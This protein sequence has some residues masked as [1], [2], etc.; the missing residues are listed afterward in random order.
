MIEKW[1]FKPA[2]WYQ[3]WLPMSGFIGGALCGAAVLTI[4]CLLAQL[5]RW[6]GH[7]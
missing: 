3:F 6:S 5:A 4:V 7:G 1:I 2:R